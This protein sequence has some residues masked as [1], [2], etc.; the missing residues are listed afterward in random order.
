MHIFMGRN[1]GLESRALS[2]RVALVGWILIVAHESP[3][4]T[5]RA[6]FTTTLRDQLD[7]HFDASKIDQRKI[8]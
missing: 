4:R 8:D 2:R 1:T 6:L 5:E 3:H 7:M